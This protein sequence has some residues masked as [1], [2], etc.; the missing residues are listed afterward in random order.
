M[1]KLFYALFLTLILGCSSGH[2]VINYSINGQ[3]LVEH[4]AV[5]MHLHL[6]EFTLDHEL[7]DDAQNHAEYMAS[8]DRLTHNPSLLSRVTK[9]ATRYGENI[10]WNQETAQEAMTDWM[11]SAGHK[12]NILDKTYKNI[13]F[14]YK[15]RYWC[16]IF[17]D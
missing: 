16:V 10:A 14:G 11:N 4:N 12:R 15:D 3:L 5:R 9:K 6:S 13:G 17:S 7:C 1:K 2:E 8:I